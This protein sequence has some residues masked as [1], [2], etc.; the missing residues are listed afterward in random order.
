MC[1]IECFDVRQQR[2]GAFVDFGQDG[3]AGDGVICA[4]AVQAHDRGGRVGVGAVSEYGSQ[5]VGAG[6]GLEGELER[7]YDQIESK[8]RARRHASQCAARRQS[9]Q[10]RGGEVGLAAV[11]SSGPGLVVGAEG[12]GDRDP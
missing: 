5:R 10:V 7:P 12:G 1:P 11:V 8:A 3:C 4:A 9:L 6:A 2:R